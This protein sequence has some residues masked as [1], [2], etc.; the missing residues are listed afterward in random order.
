MEEN[1]LLSVDEVADYLKIPK[2]TLYKMC[3]DRE[4]PS[5]KIG[6]H[7]RFDR[8]SVEKWFVGKMQNPDMNGGLK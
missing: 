5:A 7:W 1:R 2:S 4:I 3:L 8:K 6:K